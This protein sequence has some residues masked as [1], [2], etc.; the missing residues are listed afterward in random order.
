[1]ACP[2]RPGQPLGE[3]GRVVTLT[4]SPENCPETDQRVPCSPSVAIPD[5]APAKLPLGFKVSFFIVW[6]LFVPSNEPTWTP[7]SRP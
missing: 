3:I 5:V 7:V 2:V 6:T 1:M 4:V